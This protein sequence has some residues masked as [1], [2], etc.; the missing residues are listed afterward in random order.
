MVNCGIPW[1][2]SFK[3][4]WYNMAFT[5]VY[6]HKGTLYVTFILCIYIYIY[7][8]MYVSVI[9]ILDAQQSWRMPQEFYMYSFHVYA[10]FI[11]QV[12]IFIVSNSS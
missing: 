12:N 2:T 1:F 6:F 5:M 9:Y 4:P 7:I 3:T 11:Y 10:C 8:Y